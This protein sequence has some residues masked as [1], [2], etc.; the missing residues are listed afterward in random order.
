MIALKFHHRLPV[1]GRPYLQRNQ[2]RLER[3]EARRERDQARRGQDETRKELA[4]AQ[5]ELAIVRRER[6]EARQKRDETLEAEEERDRPPDRPEP[7]FHIEQIGPNFA[8]GW[9][10]GDHGPITK[11]FVS[12]DEQVIAS[13]SSFHPRRDVAAGFPNSRFALQSGFQLTFDAP[14]SKGLSKLSIVCEQEGNEWLLGERLIAD[15]C[16]FEQQVEEC[17]YIGRSS[18][19]SIIGKC[20]YIIY[21]D[22]FLDIERVRAL[23][24]VYELRGIRGISDYIRYLTSCWSHFNF[25]AGS[26]PAANSNST[27][28]NKDFFC[29]ANSPLELM[30]IAHH[31]YVLKSY[32]VEGAFAEFGCFKGF[33]SSMLSVACSL[34]GIKMHVYD[35]FEGLPSST[36]SYYE[37]GE[38]SGSLEEVQRNIEQF[39]EIE[40]IIF[41][42]DSLR[43][44]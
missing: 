44:A 20:S 9:V 5:R 3:D 2:A 12:R 38:F 14:N 35:S 36:S 21:K 22:S 39:G 1:V 17:K 43:I 19:P 11:V 40:P 29:K 10:F 6:D 13:I 31:L 16:A 27:P 37:K 15:L 26:F 7:H 8:V 4:E 25:V 30:A 42:R 41:H 33:S 23:L 34:L 18:Y 24:D 32:G 28:G